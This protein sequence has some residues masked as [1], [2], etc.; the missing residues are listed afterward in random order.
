MFIICKSKT[1]SVEF[2]HDSKKSVSVSPSVYEVHRGCDGLLMLGP[3]S[4][5]N[6]RY[7]PVGVGVALLK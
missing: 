1:D 5:T 3:E 4:E 2:I 6:R 7:G